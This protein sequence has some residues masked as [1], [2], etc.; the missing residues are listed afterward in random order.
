MVVRRRFRAA[1][2]LWCVCALLSA[3]AAAQQA[4]VQPPLSDFA[5][6]NVADDFPEVLAAFGGATPT[7]ADWTRVAEALVARGVADG[8][9]A[10]ALAAAWK[11]F[12]DGEDG[13]PSAATAGARAVVDAER[14]ITLTRPG[15]TLTLDAHSDRV[16]ALAADDGW[17]VSGSRDRTLR[18]WNGDAATFDRPLSGARNWITCVAAARAARRAAAGDVDGRITV[19]E[20][21]DGPVAWVR[22][23]DDVEHS[24]ATFHLAFVANGT[25]VLSIGADGVVRLRPVAPRDGLALAPAH[26][27][28]V[29]TVAFLGDGATLVS[30]GADLRLLAWPLRG[31]PGAPPA[32]LPSPH[33]A[34]IVAVAASSDGKLIV[35]ADV[36]GVVAAYDAA[37]E[38]RPARLRTTAHLGVR[39]ESLAL[40]PGTTDVYAGCLDGGVRRI[41]VANGESGFLPEGHRGAVKGLAFDATGARLV[42]AGADNRVLLHAFAPGASRPTT[43]PIVLKPPEDAVYGHWHACAFSPDGSRIAAGNL[44]ANVVVW[45]ARGGEPQHVL[46]GHS[47]SVEGV[48]WSRDGARLLST[49]ADGHVAVWDAA[50]GALLRRVP[51]GPLTIYTAAYDPEGRIVATAGQDGAVVLFSAETFAPLRVLGGRPAAHAAACAPDGAYVAAAYDDGLRLWDL[52]GP[53]LLAHWPCASVPRAVAFVDGGSRLAAW[54]DAGAALVLDVSSG[55]VAELGENEAAP[56]PPAAAAPPTAAELAKRHGPFAAPFFPLRGY[57]TG[58]AA[59]EPLAAVVEDGGVV[60]VFR[61]RS[62]DG[63]GRDVFELRAETDGAWAVRRLTVDAAGVRT[64]KLVR[65][66]DGGRFGTGLDGAAPAKAPGAAP[67]GANDV[68]VEGAEAVALAPGDGRE[69]AFTVTNR[70][71]QP[72]FGLALRTAA[73]GDVVLHG[74]GRL[75][76]LD[77]G[78]SIAL[79][80]YLERRG[81]GT[82]EPVATTVL[83]IVVAAQNGE[84]RRV[85]LVKVP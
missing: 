63:A 72:L 42:T 54:D 23:R 41:D 13:P 33:A 66:D 44:A 18:L 81:G 58:G 30:G 12:A 21:S 85:L 47:G 27:H 46:R 70:G 75:S 52:D 74:L 53:R 1:A 82:A 24:D 34:S 36:D 79:R 51:A 43:T 60:R 61:T 15:G 73:R 9:S 38:S 32:A 84:G 19:G 35:S 64:A 45:D 10:A 83:D 76:R 26:Q 69:I 5:A 14:R 17:I 2:R 22:L 59:S 7:D 11:R 62:G 25:R 28:D 67:A 37:T 29:R 8:P 6:E 48:A 56:T 40:R 57:A 49:S 77:P 55:E 4:F 20:A 80:G 31:P 65:A 39:V 78:A 16:T 71:A 68:L 3:V 50:T